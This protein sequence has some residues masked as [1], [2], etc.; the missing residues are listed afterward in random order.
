MC[1]LNKHKSKQLSWNTEEAIDA[2]SRTTPTNNGYVVL[3][4]ERHNL[5]SD[6]T[7]Q[8]LRAH[9]AVTI[10]EEVNALPEINSVLAVEG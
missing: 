3:G 6:Q 8:N 5:H 7:T 9:I 4:Y 1:Q 2:I 10:M